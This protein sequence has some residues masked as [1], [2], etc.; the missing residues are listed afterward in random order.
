M[1]ANV[2]RADVCY[3]V[4]WESCIRPFSWRRGCR[5]VLGLWHGSGMVRSSPT[6][7]QRGGGRCIFLTLSSPPSLSVR[8]CCFF[9]YVSVNSPSAW[10]PLALRQCRHTREPCPHLLSFSFLYSSLLYLS[11]PV[12]PF[13][14]TLYS[15][16]CW[17]IIKK[18]GWRTLFK[19]WN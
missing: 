3:V 11:S 16:F 9:P 13:V 19:L 4:G 7:C 14:F 8:L 15:L 1:E 6:E 17:Q 2:Y 5:S 12:I 18:K 10:C